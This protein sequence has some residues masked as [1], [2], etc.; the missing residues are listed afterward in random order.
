MPQS[1]KI[2]T[3]PTIQA[4]R[5]EQQLAAAQRADPVNLQPRQKPVIVERAWIAKI[6]SSPRLHRC[7][8]AISSPRPLTAPQPNN[9]LDMK[10]LREQIE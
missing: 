4:T 3:T 6:R 9:R 5:L 2:Q 1:P 10:R 7:L 8:D